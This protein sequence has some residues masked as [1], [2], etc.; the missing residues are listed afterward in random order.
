[1]GGNG[2]NLM[3]GLM[4]G[5]PPPSTTNSPFARTSPSMTTP[6]P[7]A[8][9]TFRTVVFSQSRRQ[10]PTSPPVIVREDKDSDQEAESFQG[11]TVNQ[12]NNIQGEEEEDDQGSEH[13]AIDIDVDA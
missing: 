1:M 2:A 3:Q 11:D 13:V 9:P 10:R 7:T 8:V 5:N 12:S 4:G 6:P